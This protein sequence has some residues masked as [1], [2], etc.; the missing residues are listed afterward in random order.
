RSEC[1]SPIR[2]CCRRRIVASQRSLNAVY[3]LF[4]LLSLPRPSAARAQR[5]ANELDTGQR[6][7][8]QMR[9]ALIQFIANEQG[10]SFD[11]SLAYAIRWIFDRHC[12]R[13]GT[14]KETQQQRIARLVQ[15]V[16]RGRSLHDIQAWVR[17]FAAEQQSRSPSPAT[18]SGSTT[19]PAPETPAP[20]EPT[21][22]PATDPA[23]GS[24]PD[25][26]P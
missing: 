11:S 6:T 20:P 26:K 3:D 2:R 1:R 9:D 17:D 22:D 13:N 7:L 24:G 12:V 19:K 10:V 5:L 14:S 23:T 15:E 25:P 16:K 21:P 8:T 4:D 18:S